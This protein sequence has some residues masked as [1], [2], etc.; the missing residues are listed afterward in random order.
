MVLATLIFGEELELYLNLSPLPDLSSGK[1]SSKLPL[2]LS[3]TRLVSK[4]I[5]V[6]NDLI[7]LFDMSMTL[8]L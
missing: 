6:G 8:S 5:S 1:A 7:L 3:D 2:A 4:S